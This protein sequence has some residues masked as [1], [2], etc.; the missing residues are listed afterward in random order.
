MQHVYISCRA[1]VFCI[2]VHKTGQK[3][4]MV[5]DDEMRRYKYETS[6]L[7]DDGGFQRLSNTYVSAMHDAAS[8]EGRGH[9]H[10][11]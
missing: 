6:I 2:Y 11:E 7:L 8:S 10:L 1:P 9:A 4:N 5:G 3:S